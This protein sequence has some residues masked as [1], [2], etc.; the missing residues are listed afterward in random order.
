MRSR[1]FRAK[2]IAGAITVS[3]MGGTTLAFATADAGDRLQAWY[4]SQWN[5]AKESILAASQKDAKSLWKELLPWK[6]NHKEEAAVHI[7]S[8]GTEEE[9]RASQAILDCKDAYVQDLHRQQ[10]ALQAAMPGLFDAHIAQ[11]NRNVNTEAANKATD[12]KKEINAAIEKQQQTS[13]H[14]V[15]VNITATKDEAVQSLAQ[16]IAASKKDLGTLIDKEKTEAKSQIM[17]NLTSAVNQSVNDITVQAG[18][19]ESRAKEQIQTE[20]ARIEDEAK[21]ALDAVVAEIRSK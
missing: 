15:T 17:G 12:I 21:A 5:T 10:Q 1:S 11:L 6:E 16:T 19:C 3:L 7:A 14:E 4:I 18:E 2:M 8:A 9:R 13:L 20:A